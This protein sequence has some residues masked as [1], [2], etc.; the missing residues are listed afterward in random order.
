MRRAKTVELNEKASQGDANAALALLEKSMDRGHERIGML[1]YLMAR[2]LG[3]S[4]ELRHHT[5]AEH[6]TSKMSAS[7]LVSLLEE[8]QRRCRG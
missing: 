2:R 6:V 4:L 1:R 3:A 7:A 5:Y 8:A